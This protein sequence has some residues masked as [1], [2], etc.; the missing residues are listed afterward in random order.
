MAGLEHEVLGPSA[1]AHA[2]VV[3][4]AVAHARR[5]FAILRT[6]LFIA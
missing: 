6:G 4:D 1:K 2:L 3:D 5:M